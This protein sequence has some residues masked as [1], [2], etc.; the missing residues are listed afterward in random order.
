M[1]F[2]LIFTIYAVQLA[3]IIFIKNME[4]KDF[5]NIS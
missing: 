2:H 4:K 3:K 5:P 1:E